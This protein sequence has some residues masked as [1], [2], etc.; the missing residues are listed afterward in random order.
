MFSFGKLAPALTSSAVEAA[1]AVM[2]NGVGAGSGHG[3]GGDSRRRRRGT[4]T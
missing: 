3:A 1:S 4:N 2:A